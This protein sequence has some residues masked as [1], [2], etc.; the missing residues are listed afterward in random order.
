MSCFCNQV[1][2]MRASDREGSSLNWKLDPSRQAVLGINEDR[3]SRSKDC[4]NPLCL[5]SVW[6]DWSL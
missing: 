5:A 6:T 4:D 2:E 3:K 1:S